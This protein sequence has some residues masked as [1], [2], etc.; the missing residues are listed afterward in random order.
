MNK[1]KW[2]IFG[3][4][5]PDA[6]IS[7]MYGDQLVKTG[8]VDHNTK[9]LFDSSEILLFSSETDV[10]VHG[11][12]PVNIT[13][14]AGNVT[15][16]RTMARYPA[17]LKK[18]PSIQGYIWIYQPIFDSKFSVL[19]NGAPPVREEQDKQLT[20]EWNY[21][22]NTNDVMTYLHLM[23]NGPIRWLV[24]YDVDVELFQTYGIYTQPENV[25]PKFGYQ[26]LPGNFDDL[27]KMVTEKFNINC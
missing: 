5:S 20:G 19:I 22:L 8:A 7:V 6:E 21:R 26:Y 11:A 2:H 15:V 1:R 3:Q 16:G 18:Q 13:V 24:P 25:V 27:I 17:F 10:S 23:Y 9:N 12:L 14:V 4:A